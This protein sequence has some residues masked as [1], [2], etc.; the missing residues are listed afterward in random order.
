MWAFLVFA[1]ASVDV[2]EHPA[3]FVDSAKR[4]PENKCIKEYQRYSPKSYR[5]HKATSILRETIKRNK[6]TDLLDKINSQK[7]FLLL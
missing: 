6:M 1:I 3:N 4:L 2:E 5:M 7:I